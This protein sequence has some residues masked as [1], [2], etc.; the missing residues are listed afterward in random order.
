MVD[1]PDPL[2]KCVIQGALEILRN[3][4][5]A[6]LLL[7]AVDYGHNALDVFVEGLAFLQTLE[8]DRLSAF[9]KNLLPT[10]LV[11]RHHVNRVGLNVDLLRQMALVLSRVIGPTRLLLD[12]P[13]Q[14][15]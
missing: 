5:F 14:E 8:R 4:F 10:L 2:H 7:N 9:A 1:L 12:V 15:L 11:N 3:P 13:V 6:E